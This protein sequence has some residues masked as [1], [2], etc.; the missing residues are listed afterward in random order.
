MQSFFRHFGDVCMSLSRLHPSGAAVPTRGHKWNVLEPQAGVLGVAW[1]TIRE[2]SRL[3][4]S[5]PKPKHPD[6]CTWLGTC[7]LV[8]NLHSGC[9]VF[10][11]GRSNSYLLVSSGAKIKLSHYSVVVFAH[12]GSFAQFFLPHSN[13]N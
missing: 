5:T 10:V 7:I 9:W 1:P 12:N 4:G 6:G 2:G 8:S 13:Q 3:S 11:A